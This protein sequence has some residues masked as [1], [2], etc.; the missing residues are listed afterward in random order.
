MKSLFLLLLAAAAAP[1][2]PGAAPPP[3]GAR[4]PVLFVSPMGEP[5]RTASRE[6]GLE[7]WF[8]GADSD[9]DG[10][11]GADEMR[12]DAARFYALLETDGDG[13]IEPSEMTRYESEIAPE[14]QLGRGPMSRREIVR[15]RR[16]DEEAASRGSVLAGARY[17]R[18][19]G[20]DRYR[21]DEDLEGAGRFGLINMPQPV[22]GADSDLN[23]G[24][25]AAE[26]AAAAGQRFLMLDTDRDGKLTRPELL[27]QLPRIDP[28]R[29][30]RRRG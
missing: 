10:A 20:G 18:G 19:G 29:E 5:F 7:L 3:G 6:A 15:M 16:D 14:I 27:T 21:G 2:P 9:G 28:R 1:P 12:R 24:I 26:F 23:R 17:I 11:L 4:P 8:A 13:E 25:S 22:M 30:R